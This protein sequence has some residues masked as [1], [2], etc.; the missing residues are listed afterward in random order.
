[1]V[2]NSFGLIA[3]HERAIRMPALPGGPVQK[4]EEYERHAREC[5]ALARRAV[6]DE[7][8]VHLLAM[9]ETWLGLAS[10]RARITGI[11]SAEAMVT[12]FGSQAD[13]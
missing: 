11:P 6:S 9:A 3:L 1:L 4:A 7:E 5:Q 10:Q 12:K 2:W 13:E 8:R